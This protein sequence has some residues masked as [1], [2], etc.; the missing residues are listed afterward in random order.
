MID[1]SMA[2]LI[3]QVEAPWARVFE[4]LDW[5]TFGAQYRLDRM[6]PTD[7]EA[8]F[9]I[10]RQTYRDPWPRYTFLH[11][12]LENPKAVLRVIRTRALP[13]RLAG[14]FTLRLEKDL[15][16]LTNITLHPE[17]RGRGLGHYALAYAMYLAWTLGAQTM[18]LEV[19]V[20]NERAIALYRKF[21]F[22]TVRIIPH[23]YPDGE[24]ALRM[25]APLG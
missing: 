12:M 20:T 8:V 13:V 11:E 17:Y 16:H 19:R 6:R 25:E 3:R 9:A 24:D 2:T 7:L 4:R 18:Y 1:T 10:E 22:Q 5:P 21:G 15:V 14:Y 23:Y